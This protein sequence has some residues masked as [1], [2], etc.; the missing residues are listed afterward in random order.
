MADKGILMHI[1]S[2]PSPYGIGSLGQK[3]Y[4]FVDFLK[5]AGQTLWQVLPQNP[6]GYGDSPYQS[7]SA[8]AGNPYFI[9]I[10]TLIEEK[11]LTREQCDNYFFGSDCESVDYEKL[12]FYRYPLLRSAFFNFVP[13][14]KY[15]EFVKKNEYWLEEYALFMALKEKN[16][17]KSWVDWDKE[18]RAHESETLA[19]IGEEYAKIIDFYKFVQYKFFE[20][21]FAL[22]KYANK[23]GIRI[24]GDMP[25]YVAMDSAEVWSEK[26]LFMINEKDEPQRVACSV[27]DKK[28]GYAQIWGNPLYNW[29]E[30][31]KD[32]YSWWKKRFLMAAEM[33]DIIRID[34]F[35]GFFEYYSVPYGAR[36]TEKIVSV[37]G[38]GKE[39]FA[40]VGADR[41][42]IIAENLGND[43]DELK[44]A[45]T[46]LGFSGMNIMELECD[47]KNLS[48]EV[49]AN[50]AVYTSTH[51]DNTLMGWYDSLSEN[52]KRAVRKL[53]KISRGDD[54]KKKLLEG[55]LG[56]C[57]KYK[58]VPIQDYL[59][60]GSGKR[61]NIPG[62][63]GGNWLF[64][65][66][67]GVFDKNFAEYIKNI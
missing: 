13:D 35:C 55:A 4:E 11:L 31:E 63:L 9:D 51:D 12:F 17:Y 37:K 24:I 6:T 45:M 25:I 58:I 62:T 26:S 66:R 16:H 50:D 10:D 1:S 42:D 18:Q 33:Y 44:S 23:N 65:V 49:C 43:T 28:S 48:W 7:A 47:L 21:W 5:D 36:D 52:K 54:V 59:G 67:D 32:G 34:H 53:F 56:K 19:E 57:A 39:F 20:Q 27:P 40:K 29:D 22:K 41:L 61:M 3:A 46:E 30:M 14:E 38:P 8:F 64:R 15:R 2:L 60:Y